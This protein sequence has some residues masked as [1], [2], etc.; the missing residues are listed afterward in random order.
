MMPFSFSF[1]ID[2]VAPGEHDCQIT[3]LDP[4]SEKTS[5]WRAPILIVP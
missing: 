5:F 1:G 4:A 3:I 2:R